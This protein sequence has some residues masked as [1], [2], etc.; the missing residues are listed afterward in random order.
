M[1]NA[2]FSHNY[3]PFSLPSLLTAFSHSFVPR[4][5]VLKDLALF[6]VLRGH[7]SPFYL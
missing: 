7:S 1:S 4:V 3:N 5:C 6:L 2:D